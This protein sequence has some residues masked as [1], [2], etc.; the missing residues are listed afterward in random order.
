MNSKQLS[1]L[2]VLGLV[3]GGLGLYLYQGRE[4]SYK[5]SDQSIGKKVLGE[6]PIND[7][8]QITIKN[9]TNELNLIKQDD[10]WKVRERFSYPANFSEISEFVRKTSELKAVQSMK[11]GLSQ[12]GRFEL[13]KPDKA[14]GDEFR[15]TR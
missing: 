3:I 13:I 8:A 14:T 10:L 4:A 12:F 7:V 1:I 15:N 2:L 5:P 11:V 6:F 9:A